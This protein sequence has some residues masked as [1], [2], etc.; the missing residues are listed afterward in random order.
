MSFFQSR[1]GRLP[2]PA[3]AR[4]AMCAAVAAAG[5]CL[6]APAAHAQSPER[7][8]ALINA[9]RTSAPA[10]CMGR[11]PQKLA[12]LASEPALARV[13]IGR[14]TILELALDKAGYASD[15]AEAISL[16]GARDEQAAMEAIENRYC[17][18]L[19]NPQFSAMGV[20]RTGDGWQIVLARPMRM[21][22]LGDWRDEGRAVLQAVNAVR[23]QARTCGEQAFPAAPALVWNDAL[24][25]AALEHSRD[26]VR[27]KYLTHQGKNG[28]MVA[29]RAEQAGYRWHTIAEN[30]ASGFATPETAV[31]SWLG[32]PGHCANMMNAAFTEMGAAYDINTARRPGTVYWTQV[33]GVPK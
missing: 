5:A 8:A 24:G 13:R 31:E 33:F 26:M 6:A 21:I 23:A 12:P 4:R 11:P 15:L 14:G 28:S 17:I 16:V 10:D 29:D 27:M 1:A 3:F 32:S 2:R 9:Y 30:I 18:T 22:K 20:A 19:L 25:N 7:L